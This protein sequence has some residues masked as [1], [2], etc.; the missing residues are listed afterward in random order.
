LVASRRIEV[1]ITCGILD[2]VMNPILDDAHGYRM[3]H[4][5]TDKH[6]D[7]KLFELDPWS[8][9]IKGRA[10]IPGQIDELPSVHLVKALSDRYRFSVTQEALENIIDEL[11]YQ[12]TYCMDM[13]WAGDPD[14]ILKWNAYER[15]A[16]S[17]A[18]RLRA[19]LEDFINT[20][21]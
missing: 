17:N 14:E 1:E 3:D 19:K 15:S 8:R 6:F 4:T 2:Y 5:E 21:A 11:D 9:A 16:R 12:E 20:P 13:R 7:S 18:N 10:N